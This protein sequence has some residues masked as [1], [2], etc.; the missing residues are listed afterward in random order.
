MSEDGSSLA[1]AAATALEPY[2]ILDTAPERQF[3]RI[4]EIARHLL[5]MPMAS[6]PLLTR[7][8][9][10]FK[11]TAGFAPYDVPIQHSL[12]FGA[13]QGR[14]VFQVQDLARDPRFAQNPQVAGDKQLRFVAAAP[15]ILSSGAAVGAL[16]VLDW[17]PRLPLEGRELRL[18]EDLAAIAVDELELRSARLRLAEGEARVHDEVAARQRAEE[19]LRRTERLAS[20]GTLAAGVGHEI[21]NPLSF[22]VANVTFAT[23][24]VARSR[25][26][27]AGGGVDRAGEA[28]GALAETSEALREAADGAERVRQI[29]RDLRS[30]SS[31]GSQRTHPV[32]V[33]AVLENALRIAAHELRHR[34]RIAREVAPVSPVLGGE[35]ELTQVF[36]NLLVN[37]AHAIPEGAAGRHEVR[38]RLFEE[39][40]R[41]VT[42][43][44][45]TGVGMSRE[46]QARLF[47]PF[48]TTKGPGGGIG[49]SLAICHGVVTA[50]GGEISVSSEPGQGSVF[51]VAFPPAPPAAI[52]MERPA[53]SSGER[54]GRILVVDDEPL[55]GKALMRVLGRE[56]AVETV[57]RA[58]EA[59]DLIAAGERFDVILCDISMPEMTGIELHERLLATDLD[60]A[61]RMIFISGG[62]FSEAARAFL[63]RFAG[64]RFDKPFNNAELR[65]GIR[66]WLA[67]MPPV[68]R[69]RLAK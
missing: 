35:G 68:R 44:A 51:R 15:L 28:L 65:E 60:Q 9:L 37:A 4:V 19:G 56:H 42:E 63:E 58:R 18:L 36:V 22:V 13:V 7:E 52:E 61:D 30:V 54:R 46:V 55:V 23:A 6:L 53:T 33:S 66:Q 32:D 17:R 47:E 67:R 16:V 64:R 1:A 40:G 27:L 5:A 48:F 38:V 69:L 12:A 62:T 57:T 8:R 34:A 20:L 45:D 2:A 49:L 11:A 41:V 24:E 26:L 29:V 10:F 3:D 50:L 14:R 43:I 31:L 25:K 39:G 59:L 21:N